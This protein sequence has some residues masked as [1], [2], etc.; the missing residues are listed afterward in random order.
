MRGIK[1]ALNKALENVNKEI[2]Q[3]ASHGPTAAGLASEG[4]A[5]GYRAAL[6]DV[7]AALDGWSNDQSRYWPR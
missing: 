5:G 4:F 2:A 7:R 3:N 6:Y 1:R